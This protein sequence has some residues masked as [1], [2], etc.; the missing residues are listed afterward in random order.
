MKGTKADN[1]RQETKRIPVGDRWYYEPIPTPEV[2]PS[3]IELRDNL[4]LLELEDDVA[5]TAD[6]N[7]H[8]LERPAHLG[9]LQGIPNEHLKDLSNNELGACYL[10][11]TLFFDEDLEWCM[12]TGWGG[13]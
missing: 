7:Q 12:I 8:Q 11:G 1:E 6:K 2:Q 13:S 5:I 9:K 10:H 3:Q 4:N